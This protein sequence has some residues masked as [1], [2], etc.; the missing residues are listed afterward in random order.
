MDLQIRKLKAIEYLI[1]L[2]DEKILNKIEET[3]IEYKDSDSKVIKPFSKTQL[4]TRA[5]R[6][7]K[8]YSMGKFKTQEQIETDSDNW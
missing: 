7:N 5:K 4:I 1:N 8:D 6:A 3:I 2:Q